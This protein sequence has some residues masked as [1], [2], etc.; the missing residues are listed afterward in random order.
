MQTFCIAK[1]LLFFN[2]DSSSPL[3]VANWAKNIPPKHK[4]KHQP[5]VKDGACS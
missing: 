5:C 4:R 1:V 3:K 2:Y